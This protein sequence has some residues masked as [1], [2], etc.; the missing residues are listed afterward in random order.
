MKIAED[1]I[2]HYRI[3]GVKV[4]EPPGLVHEIRK[5]V[6]YPETHAEDIRVAVFQ[7]VVLGRD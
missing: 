6:E 2:R 7:S 1:G 3:L 5:V 4:E